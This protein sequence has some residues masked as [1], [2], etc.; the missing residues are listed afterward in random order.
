MSRLLVDTS[1]LSALFRGHPEAAGAAR[2]ADEL[3]VNPAVIAEILAGALKTGGAHEKSLRDFLKS[4][5]VRVVAIDEE[6]ARPYAVIFEAL[7][8]V[9]KPI[10]TND[11]WI[12]ASAMQHGL[13]VLTADHHFGRVSQI[14]VEM[15]RS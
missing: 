13:T 14:L 15:I 10:P 11:I 3:C 7:R 4:P 5:R 2:R 8:K 12:A 9:G 6:T 1:A